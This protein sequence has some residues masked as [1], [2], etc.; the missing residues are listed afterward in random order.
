MHQKNPRER[1]F[2][3][4]RSQESQISGKNRAPVKPSRQA[5]LYCGWCITIKICDQSKCYNIKKPNK[6]KCITD[7]C[8]TRQMCNYNVS[9]GKKVKSDIKSRKS[10]VQPTVRANFIITCIF[11]LQ[12]TIT[13]TAICRTHCEAFVPKLLDLSITA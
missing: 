5:S 7:I 9:G 1:T 10:K 4:Q 11:I 6:K 8:V 2:D 13:F 12:T 3:P